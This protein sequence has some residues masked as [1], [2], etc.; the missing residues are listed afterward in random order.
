MLPI[1]TRTTITTI[2]AIKVGFSELAGLFPGDCG[3]EV[4]EDDVVGELVLEGELV[5]ELL[6]EGVDELVSVGAGVIMGAV[7]CRTG[8]RAPMNSL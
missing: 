7:P 5:R 8:F 6:L 3:D 2:I 1:T 4:V